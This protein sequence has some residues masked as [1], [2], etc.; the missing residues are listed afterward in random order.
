MRMRLALS[1]VS[2]AGCA[3]AVDDADLKANRRDHELEL[4][5]AQAGSRLTR[6]TSRRSTARRSTS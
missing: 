3:L 1:I 4:L 2:V 6:S 5:T